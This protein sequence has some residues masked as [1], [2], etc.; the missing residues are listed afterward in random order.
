MQTLIARNCLFY[1]V[2]N[3]VKQ[4]KKSPTRG[5][6]QTLSDIYGTLNLIIIHSSQQILKINVNFN[7]P[8]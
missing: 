7:V 1:F 6:G 4:Q 3:I 8:Q 5:C 2:S